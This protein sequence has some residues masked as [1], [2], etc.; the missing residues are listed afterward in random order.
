M[1]GKLPDISTNQDLARPVRVPFCQ[2][3]LTLNARHALRLCTRQRALR[4]HAMQTRTGTHDAFREKSMET[5]RV[6]HP[7][8]RNR[9]SPHGVSGA[10]L[11]GCSTH[12]LAPEGGPFVTRPVSPVLRHASCVSPVRGAGQRETHLETRFSTRGQTAHRDALKHGPTG[13]AG[14]RGVA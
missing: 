5:H 14:R 10:N 2:G 6:T 13:G 8:L 3:G 12:R 7:A 1:A 11:R 9:S 4:L